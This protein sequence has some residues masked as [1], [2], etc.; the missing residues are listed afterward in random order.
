MF[1]LIC[2]VDDKKL[3]EV[4]IALRAKG[5]TAIDFAPM[6]NARMIRGKVVEKVEG[7]TSRIDL[8]IP[9]LVEQKLLS[10]DKKFTAE[11][12]SEVVQ[13]LGGSKNSY[14]EIINR[15]IKAKS[16]KRISRGVFQLTI[17][18]P[19]QKGRK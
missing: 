4:I 18:A 2:N 9:A 16:V 3:G 6:T 19:K 8:F 5:I 7:A 1:R 15:L 12:A 11:A 13:S 17:A 14:N 10:A